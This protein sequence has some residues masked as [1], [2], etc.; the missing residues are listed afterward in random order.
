MRESGR[1]RDGSDVGDRYHAGGLGLVRESRA[2][3]ARVGHAE[4]AQ[5]TPG[6][7]GSRQQCS[8]SLTQY[9]SSQIHVDV[10][11]VFMTPESPVIY[12]RDRVQRRDG[13]TQPPPPYQPRIEQD[14]SSVRLVDRDDRH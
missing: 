9:T 7:N 13:G 5:G 12:G 11:L 3:S 4:V 1:N 10:P 6:Q 14:V 8:G 2:A